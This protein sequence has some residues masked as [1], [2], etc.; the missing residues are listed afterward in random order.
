VKGIAM[1]N[2]KG[3]TL[4]ELLV[5]IAIIALLL[6][7]LM[8][9]L[10]A[11]KRKAQ[12]VVCK[13][14]LKQ[15]AL[16]YSLY[17]SDN[18]QYFPE[19]KGLNVSHMESLRG[20]YGDVNKIRTCPSAIKVDTSA[21]NNTTPPQPLSFWGHTFNAWQVDAVNAS[22]MNNEDWGIGSYCENTWI[23]RSE[24]SQGDYQ[25][26]WKKL[27]SVKDNVPIIGDGRWNNAWPRDIDLI[28]VVNPADNKNTLIAWANGCTINAYV[29]RRHKNGLNM[30]FG[31]M[32]VS[33]HDAEELWLFKWNRQYNKNNSINLSGLK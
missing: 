14:N 26:Y 29:I 30:A 25:D 13:S 18:D 6:S 12:A 27:T 10:K 7:I 31:D 2:K 1:N 19:F 16:C 22:W 32:S 8:P 23:R 21:G 4:I 9:S 33:Y 3:F 17:A 15:W 24:Q 20:Y 11:V 5:V 28:P